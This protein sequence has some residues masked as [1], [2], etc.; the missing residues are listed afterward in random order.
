MTEF[1]KKRLEYFIKAAEKGEWIR[2]GD[3]DIDFLE[4]L[5]N[6]YNNGFDKGFEEGIEYVISGEMAFEEQKADALKDIY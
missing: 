6:S 3:S 1:Q 5:K 4:Y 2:L